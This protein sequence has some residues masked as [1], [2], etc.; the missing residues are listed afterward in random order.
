MPRARRLLAALLLPPLLFLP[1]CI[2]S[3][4][5]APLDTD[6]SVTKLGAKTGES[7]ARSILWLVAWGDAGAAAAA[8]EGGITT[9]NHMDVETL[10]IFFG[11]YA[12]TT[13]IVYGD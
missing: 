3:H 10:F 12:Q 5:R 1:A 7:T 9:L 11:V 8:K 6:L 13:T 4:V 2:Y